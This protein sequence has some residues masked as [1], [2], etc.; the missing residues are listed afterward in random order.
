MWSSQVL[1]MEQWMDVRF[2]LNFI[3]IYLALL[4]S[5]V[6]INYYEFMNQN[7]SLIKISQTSFVDR[8][9]LHRLCLL[10]SLG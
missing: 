2:L 3:I 5:S 1:F 4:S 6:V 8:G 7:I 9:N 10:S